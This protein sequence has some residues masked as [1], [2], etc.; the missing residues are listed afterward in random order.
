MRILKIISGI[1][2][3]APFTAMAQTTVPVCSAATLTGVRA[4]TVAGRDVSTGAVLSKSFQ[5]VGTASFDGAGKVMLSLTSNTNIAQNVAQT[6]G[7]TYTLAANCVGT[8]VTTTGDNATFTLIAYNTGKNF[9]ITGQDGTYALSGSGSDQPVVCALSSLSGEFVFSGTGFGLASGALTGVNAIAGFMQFDGRGAVTGTWSV[10][11]NG[12]AA[13][14]TV[15]GHYSVASGCT[16]SATVSDAAGVAYNLAFVF[17]SADASNAIDLRL[18]VR[19]RSFQFRRTRPFTNPGL[20][21]TSAASGASAATPV[22]SI[23]A[24]YGSGLATGMAQPN[25]VPLPTTELTTT[26]TVNGEAVPLFYV[27][28]TQINAQMPLDIQ[29]GLATVVVS[30]GAAA[31]NA[32]AVTVACH[33]YAGDLSVRQ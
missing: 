14:A 32:A 4:I 23:F 5:S 27:S 33:G 7:G 16:A 29:P 26:V 1:V 22:G 15:S 6:W 18:R 25:S 3:A 21:V 28:P 20:S 31:S 9:T 19:W 10:S 30:N 8:L 17:T 11:L 12:S 13:T 2:L 24:L